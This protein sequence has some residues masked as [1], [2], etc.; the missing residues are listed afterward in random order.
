[1]NAISILVVLGMDVAAC[2]KIRF[3]YL[4]A[5]VLTLVVVMNVWI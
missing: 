1:M 5:L 2:Q 3:P 4:S